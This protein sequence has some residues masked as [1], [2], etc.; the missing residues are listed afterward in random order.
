MLLRSQVPKGASGPDSHDVL[1]L[2][3]LC[4]PDALA[5]LFQLMGGHLA[6]DLHVLDEVELQATLLQA[7]LPAKGTRM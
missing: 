6:Q 5:A 2:V 7:V 4:H 3:L 1:L